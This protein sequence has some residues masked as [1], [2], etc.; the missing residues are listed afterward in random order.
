MSFFKNDLELL[1]TLKLNVRAVCIVYTVQAVDCS[2][3]HTAAQIVCLTFFL[4][5]Q[6]MKM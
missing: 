2:V 5:I 3:E 1:L 4:Y 6:H